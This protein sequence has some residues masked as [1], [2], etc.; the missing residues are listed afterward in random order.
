M[1]LYGR[2]KESMTGS[3]LREI[4]ESTLGAESIHPT[5]DFSPAEAFAGLARSIAA[6][7]ETGTLP[8]DL[9]AVRP[10]GPM[11]MPP[12]QPEIARLTLDDVYRLAREADEQIDGTGALPSFLRIGNA[13]IGTGSLF[14]L[15]CA[16]YLDLSSN[17]PRAEYDVPA[18]DP[19]PKKNETDIIKQVEGYKSWPVHRRDLDMAKVV[20]FTKLQLWTLKPAKMSNPTIDH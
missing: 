19:Y 13:R 16:A 20:E 10:L 15:F 18:F 4:A 12:A 7:Q 3:E 6:R 11:D 8:R 17:K 14:A 9:P 5:Q 1:K 2:Q